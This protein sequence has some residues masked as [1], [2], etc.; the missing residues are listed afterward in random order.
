MYS[1]HFLILFI[2]LSSRVTSLEGQEC[3]EAL[4]ENVFKNEPLLKGF[5]L[6]NI[7]APEASLASELPLIGSSDAWT[8]RYGGNESEF[9]SPLF[10]LHEEAPGTP[11]FWLTGIGIQNGYAAGSSCGSPVPSDNSFITKLKV[12]TGSRMNKADYVSI[13]APYADEKGSDGEPI[14]DLRLL[15]LNNRG[16]LL[17]INFP[18]IA[19]DEISLQVSVYTKSQLKIFINEFNFR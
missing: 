1:L 7:N 16:R 2:T 12:T 10:V 9:I 14:L 15:G 6:N 8:L 11:H 13:Q 3:N 5:V 4:L 17:K 19:A 18:P